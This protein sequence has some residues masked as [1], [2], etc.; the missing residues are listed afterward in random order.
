MTG[1]SL[2][3]NLLQQL[4]I[5]GKVDVILEPVL[6]PRPYLHITLLKGT[7]YRNSQGIDPGRR[8]H[9]QHLHGDAD[10]LR[11]GHIRRDH[12][13]NIIQKAQNIYEQRFPLKTLF[14]QRESYV[15]YS[16]CL[17]TFLIAS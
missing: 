12:G 1:A 9:G 14:S 6:Q 7:V 10:D 3:E 5:G 8:Q 16:V 15:D 17:H 4:P 13:Q 2:R 11:V